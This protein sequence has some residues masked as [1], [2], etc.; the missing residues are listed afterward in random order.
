MD[1]P[2]EP[3]SGEKE[4]DIMTNWTAADLSYTLTFDSEPALPCTVAGIYSGV[5]VNAL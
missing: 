4:M 3:F 2:P 5:E 1:T